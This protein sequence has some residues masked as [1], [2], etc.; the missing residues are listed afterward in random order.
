MRYHMTAL[1]P[2]ARE[3]SAAMRAALKDAGIEPQEVG[4]VN[5]HATSTPAG[6]GNESRAIEVVF[7]EHALSGALK[8][9]GTK[10]MTGH[11]LERG[12]IGGRH[13]C[14]GA[15]EPEAAADDQPGQRGPGVQARLCAERGDRPQL[16]CGAIEFVWFG[17]LMPR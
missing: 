5:A 8:V 4:Y 1:P 6:D 10:S 13:L 11:L 2:K 12:R 17:G 3:P 7:G 16:R 15:G 9:S 14:A